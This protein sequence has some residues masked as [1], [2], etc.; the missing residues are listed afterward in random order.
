MIRVLLVEDD[1]EWHRLIM[2]WLPGFAIDGAETYSDALDLL[3]WVPYDVAI[4][5]L[6]IVKS[7]GERLVLNNLGSTLLGHLQR[8]HPTTPRIAVTGAPPGA[9]RGFIEKYRLTELLLKGTLSPPDVR[10]AVNRAVKTAVGGLSLKLR[11]ERGDRWEEFSEWHDSTLRRIGQ[12]AR[13]LE[14]ESC[15]PDGALRRTVSALEALK[16][17]Q[18]AFGGDSGAVATM[19]AR[20]RSRSDLDAAI[21]EF[22][23]L[24]DKYETVP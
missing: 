6:N 8:H 15:K 11:G 7:S 3:R 23:A 16:T 14:A 21:V 4:V 18:A 20:I 1:S 10:D 13:S 9:V 2:A 17:T 19:L 22:A 24:R 12:R 5:D